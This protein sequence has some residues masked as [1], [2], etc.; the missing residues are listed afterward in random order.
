MAKKACYRSRAG[1]IKTFLTEHQSM[2]IYLYGEL[3]GSDNEY[4]R[5]I[6]RQMFEELRHEMDPTTVV[7]VLSLFESDHQ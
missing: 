1:A 3:F 7:N 6:G 4:Y 2:G 5:N